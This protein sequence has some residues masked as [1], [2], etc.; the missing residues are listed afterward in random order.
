MGTLSFCDNY[1]EATVFLGVVA[2][3]IELSPGNLIGNYEEFQTT[4]YQWVAD[5]L[6]GKVMWIREEDFNKTYITF[7]FQHSED[8]IAFK[9]Y[10]M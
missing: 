10:W 2:E 9:L 1:E 4:A 8:A 3:Y 5:N 7:L 6:E